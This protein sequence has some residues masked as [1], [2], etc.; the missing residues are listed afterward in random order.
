M[1]T[2]RY[3][4]TT[5]G[6]MSVSSLE[7]SRRIQVAHPTRPLL[8]GLIEET[9]ECQLR[10]VSDSCAGQYGYPS[11]CE[12]LEECEYWVRWQVNATLPGLQFSLKMPMPRTWW[13][14][15]IGFSTTGKMVVY[16]SS[17]ASWLFLCLLRAAIICSVVTAEMRDSRLVPTCLSSPCS[18]PKK[19]IS[20]PEI[21]ELVDVSNS[22]LMGRPFAYVSV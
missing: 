4:P 13:W 9:C 5:G 10:A 12:T 6:Q 20:P 14:G 1:F 17:S 11:P 3:P 19:I 22:A 18:G 7:K 21:S 8:A 15:G 16:S 2:A